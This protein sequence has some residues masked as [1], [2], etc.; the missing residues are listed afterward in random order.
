MILTH[1]RS[2]SCYSV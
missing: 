2:W 1:I